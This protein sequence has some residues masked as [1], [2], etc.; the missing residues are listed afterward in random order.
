MKKNFRFL[1][2]YLLIA[3]YNLSAQIT[4]SPQPTSDAIAQYLSQ[5]R[6]TTHSDKAVLESI[7]TD[8]IAQSLQQLLPHLAQSEVGLRL[9]QTI[10]SPAGTHYS[11]VQ[12]YQGNDVYEAM[13]RVSINKNGKIYLLVDG[14]FDTQG[15]QMPPVKSIMRH[16][17]DIINQFVAQNGLLRNEK[18]TAA[19]DEGYRTVLLFTADRQAQWVYSLHA[20]TQDRHNYD[21]YLLDL[22]GN[23]IYRRDLTHDSHSRTATPLPNSSYHY[24]PQ[25]AK[26][27]QSAMMPPC[28]PEPADCDAYIFLP[29]PLTTAQ[30]QYGSSGLIDNND[31]DS[32]QLTAERKLVSIEATLTDGVYSLEN[33][34]AKI[35]QYES[36]AVEPATSTTPDFDF[37]RSESGFEDVNSFYHLSAQGQYVQ[38]LGFDMMQGKQIYIDTHA[39]Q[40]NDQSRHRYDFNLDKH[41]ITQGEGGI[42]DAE[43]ADVIIHEFGH[44][45]STAAC[46]DCN[47]GNERSALDEALCDYLAASYSHRLSDFKWK[48]IFSWDG[49][50]PFFAG[51][52]TNNNAHYPEDVSNSSIYVTSLIFSGALVDVYESIGRGATDSLVLACLYNWSAG[53]GLDDAAEIAIL[54]DQELTG[55]KHYNELCYIFSKR[56]LYDGVCATEA[57]AGANRSICL[58]DTTILGESVIPPVGGII[59]WTPNHRLSSD[60]IAYP[61]CSP[62]RTTTYIVTVKNANTSLTD[63]VTVT[64]MYCFDNNPVGTDIKIYNTDRFATGGD[65]VVEVPLETQQVQLQLFDAAGRLVMNINSEGDER[66]ILNSIALRAGTYLLRVQADDKKSTFK[67]VKTQ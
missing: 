50:N 52:N 14:T 21:Q 7:D 67:M 27:Q 4:F 23:S 55:G 1:L 30:K 34:Y 62:D 44:A 65:A 19:D 61:L 18:I 22:Q 51:R 9:M 8:N 33:E 28:P 54:T 57:N 64:V 31:S 46:A 35:V 36:P 38:L 39:E 37:T 20:E 25:V 47:S 16:S 48:E 12:T 59:L 43:D 24:R 3:N 11:F 49:H 56:G 63:S 15:L 40:G 17:N 41:V 53:I 66:I 29:D 6:A 2:L 26:E 60:T 42:D 13:L 5:H 58:G 10:K 32:P 45:L